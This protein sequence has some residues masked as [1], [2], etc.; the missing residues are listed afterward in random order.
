MS[1]LDLA[2]SAVSSHLYEEFRK[3][4]LVSDAVP[5][6][7]QAHARGYFI[8]TSIG[9]SFHIYDGSKM[10]L[11]FVGPQFEHP[12]AAISSHQQLT[13]VATGKDVAVC[14]RG[15]ERRRLQ[16]HKAPVTQ[17]CV[18]GSGDF[19]VSA[20]TSG[21]VCV[22]DLLNIRQFPNQP[23]VTPHMTL[24]MGDTFVP[25]ALLQPSTYV[26]KVLVCSAS[27][28]MQ[29]WNVRSGKQIFQ[30]A[31]LPASVVSVVQSPVLD[32]IG[33]GLSNGSVLVH[34]LK[35]DKTLM[36]F[37]VDGPVL[38]LAF[39]SDDA[40]ILAVGDHQGQIATFDLEKRR[41]VNVAHA[42]HEAGVSALHFVANTGVLLS[43]S[44]D[45][46][47]CAWVYDQPNGPSQ[48]LR[49]RSG[50][51]APPNFIRFYGAID[52]MSLGHVLLSSGAD[53][54]LRLFSLIRDAQA[55]EFSQ[56]SLRAVANKRH[57][58]MASLRLP[59]V[60]Q[61]S[62]SDVRERD[63]HNIAT[64]HVN[65]PTVYLWWTEKRALSDVKIL[66]KD[67]SNAKS[68]CISFCGNYLAVGYESG[69]IDTFNVQSGYHRSTYLGHSLSV[70]G[71]CFD[72]TAR[73]LVSCSLDG[74]VQ[75]W[76]FHTSFVSS[77]GAGSKV[78]SLPLNL[79][80]E[81]GPVTRMM[82]HRENGLLAV[83]TDDCMI[84]LF[85]LETQRLGR[86][87][88]AQDSPVVDIAFSVDGRSLLAVTTDAHLRVYDIPSSLTVDTMKLPAVPTSI[89]VA[90]RGDFIAITFV[91][92]L[93]VSVY[94]LATGIAQARAAAAD[95]ERVTLER[96]RLDEGMV[97]GVVTLSMVPRA[98]WHNL[99][100]LDAIRERNKPLEAPKL[101]EKAPFFLPSKTAVTSTLLSRPGESIEEE[102]A[103]LKEASRVMRMGTA[104]AETPLTS[105]LRQ[106]SE[107]IAAD[108][109]VDTFY[110]AALEHLTRLAPSGVD[111][112][113]RS[114]RYDPPSG[115]DPAAN[116]F[117]ANPAPATELA[118]FVDF[119]TWAT[120]RHRDFE[121]VQAWTTV[122]L[123][124]HGDRLLP[125]VEESAEAGDVPVTALDMDLTRRMN[126]L[127]REQSQAWS[128]LS[129]SYREAIC[130]VDFA[131]R[132]VV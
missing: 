83:V 40:P 17:L 56:G 108:S 55:V 45:N 7:I 111:F 74:T 46:S 121:L 30:F 11:L 87:F 50:H 31:Q 32:V 75:V 10:R 86:V 47:I 106:A 77:A 132:A 113:I 123:R 44:A 100:H 41:L 25:T 91:D 62:W 112:E 109:E 67:G 95:Y 68:V 48:L 127:R 36:T 102:E 101:P 28:I 26:N 24:E 93:A 4:G 37:R 27:G 21:T 126:T 117:A 15:R 72:A 94:A 88:S 60:L 76:P 71:L 65:H 42:A 43:S 79:D 124:I 20:D 103:A 118:R 115:T 119:L 35:H 89:A 99:L 38:S 57:V 39:R 78:T 29:L 81:S 107:A 80:P 22:W 23:A 59:P 61:F 18:I 5:M 3:I 131:R 52:S 9:N 97:D 104:G 85:D 53:R 116:I 13:F 58:T 92:D 125:G 54:A 1:S 122:T 98:R 96:T 6:H 33:L 12:V 16:A 66:S 63:W 2:T 130:L 70:T 129:D 90:P 51:N 8:I 114:L 82:I 110:T 14:E 120:R 105:A 84:R 69:R 128:R 64:C 73:S 19:L 49:S 34:N